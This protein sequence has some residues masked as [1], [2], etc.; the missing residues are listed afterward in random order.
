MDITRE[1]SGS[2]LVVHLAGRLD[3]GWCDSVQREL[4]AAVRDGEHNIHL[5]MARVDYISSAGLAVILGLYKQ[6]HAIKGE[7]GIC[8]ASPFVQSVLKLAGLSSLIT[9]ATPPVVAAP[10]TETSRMADSTSAS[11]EIFAQKGE[12][13]RIVTVGDA[14]IIQEG[15]QRTKPIATRFDQQTF[16]VGI[17]ALGL[18]YEDS[19]TRFGEFLAAGGVATFQPSDGSNRPDFTLSEASL[20]PEG[21]LLLGL[22]G[23][24]G[25]PSLARFEATKEARS[26]GL[27][28]LAEAALDSSG[29]S[30]VALVAITETLGLVGATLRRSPVAAPGGERRLEFPQI[31]EWLSFSNEPVFRD[32]S[33]LIVGV[34]ARPDSS[35]QGMLRPMSKN[36]YGHFHAAA[37]PYRPLQK[38][39]IEMI[40][41]IAALFEA[42]GLQAVLH[43]LSD[44]RELTGTGE[45]QFLR[46]AIWISPATLADQP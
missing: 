3:A 16:A 38:G 45:S 39:E 23:H 5:E 6:L 29:A 4:D 15:S 46:G 27:T 36:L 10:K 11:Y 1:K 35:F 7:F 34:A 25:F 28:E 41:A 19:E 37:F 31:R 20:V 26:V 44:T 22:L 32:S 2:V 13:M 8:A 12:G 18:D 17:G 9:A 42:R 43:L 24:G 40:P 30:A 21:H 14:S 33:S